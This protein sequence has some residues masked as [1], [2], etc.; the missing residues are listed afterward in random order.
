M[1]AAGCRRRRR[2]SAAPKH[3]VAVRAEQ[4]VKVPCKARRAKPPPPPL[5]PPLPPTSR[6]IL[7]T[8]FIFSTSKFDSKINGDKELK[9]VPQAL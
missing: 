9:S 6:G 1:R 8:G 7:R 3:E 2:R 5:A 4:F